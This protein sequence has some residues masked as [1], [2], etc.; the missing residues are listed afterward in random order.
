M[1]GIWFAG[2]ADG[3]PDPWR[4]TVLVGVSGGR[5]ED[6]ATLASG[7]GGDRWLWEA[8]DEPFESIEASAQK[9]I[10]YVDEHYQGNVYAIGGLSLG[11]QIAA[12]AL[13]ARPGIA[14]Y[15]ALESAL[16]CPMPWVRA[17]SA[18]MARMSF[19]LLRK[20]WFAKLQAK[21][22]CLP[23]ALFENYYADSLLL[24]LNSLTNTLTSNAGYTLKAGLGQTQAR[25]LIL[26]GQKEAGVMLRSAR[27]L[28]AA[29]PRSELW[30]APG[31]KHGELS[32]NHPELY[33]QKITDFYEPSMM[34]TNRIAAVSRVPLRRGCSG[35]LY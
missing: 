12:E 6:D 23:D 25:V 3:N 17:L 28:H 22:F 34:L 14:R 13:S 21:A 35:R 33:L 31:L 18:P 11:A 5:G 24:S 2:T 26:A 10:R 9:L 29:I 7:A 8:A 4:R 16:V 1:E 32:L 20:R 19:G 27:A 15:A 30:I